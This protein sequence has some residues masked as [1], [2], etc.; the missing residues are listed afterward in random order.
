MPLLIGELKKTSETL[1]SGM[2]DFYIPGTAYRRDK[3]NI[4]QKSRT[5]IQFFYSVLIFLICLEF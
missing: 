2:P 3:I 1:Q 4:S 5:Y